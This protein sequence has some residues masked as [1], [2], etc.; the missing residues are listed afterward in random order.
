M[1]HCGAPVCSKH[2]V[3]G[4]AKRKPNS[5]AVAALGRPS[6]LGGDDERSR[7]GGGGGGGGYKRSRGGG[8]G[9]GRK[10]S[11][12]SSACRRGGPRGRLG[13]TDHPSKMVGDCLPAL[14]DV[15]WG[16][17]QYV[18]EAC[19]ES[20]KSKKQVPHDM[21][22]C[23]S[24]GKSVCRFCNTAALAEEDE[25]GPGGHCPPPSRHAF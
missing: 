13:T 21:A 7:G 9:G 4:C 15:K 2:S 20:L 3:S 14:G 8:G 17:F 6:D 1:A 19:G 25:V 10:S 5:A 16:R 11:H 18:D 12:K 23:V 22:G 24:P